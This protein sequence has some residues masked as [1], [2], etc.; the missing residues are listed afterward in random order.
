WGEDPAR[1]VASS[2]LG[3]GVKLAPE[4]GGIRLSGRWRFSSNVDHCGAAVLLAMLPGAAGAVPHFLLVHR[5]QYAI[6][7]IWRTVGLA[8]TGGDDIV[9][10]TALGPPH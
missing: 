5:D 9:I 8:A 4:K 3:V 2:F 6:E 1:A 7:D 10:A